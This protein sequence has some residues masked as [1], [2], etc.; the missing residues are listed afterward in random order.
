[1]IAYGILDAMSTG[2]NSAGFQRFAACDNDFHQIL[3][4]SARQGVN[5]FG[6]QERPPC[7]QIPAFKKNDGRTANA[8]DPSHGHA[9]ARTH[10]QD[11]DRSP[12]KYKFIK[13]LNTS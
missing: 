4:A 12:C 3:P 13:N 1:M 10:P 8:L 9:T 5:T 6:G 7:L 2:K 11:F